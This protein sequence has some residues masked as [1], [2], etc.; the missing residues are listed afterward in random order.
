MTFCFGDNARCSSDE[1]CDLRFV[2][3]YFLSYSTCEFRKSLGGRC[4]PGIIDP[5]ESGSHCES[6][7]CKIGPKNISTPNVRTC[8]SNKDC[9]F[10]EFCWGGSFSTQKHCFTKSYF[11]RCATND[12][13]KS[14]YKC[15]DNGYCSYVDHTKS[16]N[17]RVYRNT[18]TYSRDD[19]YRN[20]G[21]VIPIIFLVIALIA[22]CVI[23]CRRRSKGTPLASNV[24]IHP[25][26]PPVIPDQHAPPQYQPPMNGSTLFQTNQA[27]ATPVE[28]APPPYVEIP[29]NNTSLH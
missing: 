28:D 11:D 9:S 21:I 7:R 2:T 1:Y 23:K 10:N 14:G 18:E 6:F 3:G 19:D 20:W 26:N 8:L 12:F 24:Q 16:N 17:D 15:G 4:Y 5:C 25:A 29:A 13:C 22:W 27:N